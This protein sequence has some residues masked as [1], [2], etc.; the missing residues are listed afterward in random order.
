MLTV[1]QPRTTTPAD[2]D[3]PAPSTIE[4]VLAQRGI[5]SV[6]QP[7][8]E[9]ATGQVVGHEALSRGPA[10]TGLESPAALFAAARRAGLL[11]ELD[12]ACR[13]SSFRTA[14]RLGLHDPT[15][16]FVNVEPEV[17]DHA[18]LR[19]LSAIAEGV[20]GGLRIV[21]EITERALSARPA[22]LMRTVDAVRELGWGVALDDVGAEQASLT[23]M[24]MLRPDVVKL[25]LS[26]IQ[27]R[28]SG[29]TAEVMHAVNAYAESSGARVLAEGIETEAHLRTARALGATL[30]QGWFY[31]RPTATPEVTSV[32]RR[33]DLPGPTARPVTTSPFALLPQRAAVRR[34]SKRYLIELSKHLER[35]A[36]RLGPSC[37]V[38]STFQYARH[39]TPA[40]VLRY[41][42]L[43]ER[44]GFVCVLGD[45]LGDAA[46]VVP[47]IRGAHLAPGDPVRGEWD[48]VVLSPHFSAALLARDLGPLAAGGRRE[49]DRE[50]E[51]VLTYERTTVVAAAHSLLS[52]VA[53]QDDAPVPTTRRVV[54]VSRL[55]PGERR[56]GVA[57]TAPGPYADLADAAVRRAVLATTSGL[58]IADMTLPDEPLVFVNAGFERLA[59]FDAAEL[60]GRNCRFLQSSD[61]DR[62]ALARVRAGIDAGREVREV[63]LNLRG[64]ERT[65]WWNEIH[66]SPIHDA[67]GRVVQYMAVQTD[68][69]R[70]V[71]AERALTVEREI[72]RSYAAELERLA[73]T[74][75]LTGL[76]NRRSF[77]SRVE[78]ELLAAGGRG[79]A[80][81]LVFLDLDGFKAVND[82]HGHAVGDELLEQVAERLGV[83]LGASVPV[84]R[85]GGDEFVVA[86]TGLDP[87]HV[88]EQVGAV[89][90]RLAKILDRPFELGGLAVRAAA[91]IGVAAYP[92][93]ADGFGALL[94]LADLRMYE[95]KHP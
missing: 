22:E 70:R 49:M 30:A 92:R 87:G 18:P 1:P 2:V 86:L 94:H 68:V 90:H 24:A 28:A 62:S 77:E 84:A 15:T 35:E 44:T 80:V 8:V 14:S 7:I 46:A 82:S 53:P 64:A 3:A 6:F 76:M 52:R 12:E 45:G 79:E 72:A 54:P 31:G 55:G 61:T 33:L 50:F 66:L 88:A 75:S 5:R 42:D 9:I 34:S 58:T 81:A 83:E 56:A 67:D 39:F 21:L 26:L 78:A 38:A 85:F 36:A 73:S 4:Q 89:Q 59:G 65:P 95:I 60:L 10:G 41:H 91:S 13:Q 25:D 27:R 57:T 11:A 71:E 51:Y 48:V 17:L 20:P 74:D 43:V 16:V 63:L 47:G 19:Q 23:F 29:E 32:A 37:I 69:T 40:T 93:D